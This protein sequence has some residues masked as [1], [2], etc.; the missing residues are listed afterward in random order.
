[1]PNESGLDVR[2]ERANTAQQTALAA[3]RAG[4][5]FA[6]AAVEAGVNR[7]TVYRWVQ[8]DPAF[9]A[10]Y[11]AWRAELVESANARLLKMTERAVEVIGEALETGDRRSPSRCS[12][13]WA[14]FARANAGLPMSK[15]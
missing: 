7:A 12:A 1:M 8:R 11:N 9:R 5:S 3:L 10:A 14:R 15:C 13:R 6:K 2:V 4:S